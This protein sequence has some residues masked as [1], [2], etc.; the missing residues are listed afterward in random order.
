MTCHCL[1]ARILAAAALSTVLATPA[2]AQ[3]SS[4]FNQPRAGYTSQMNSGGRLPFT[5]NGRQGFGGMQGGGMNSAFGTS[6]FGQGNGS[7]MNSAFGNQM[8]MGGNN[9]FGLGGAN[10]QNSPFN[11]SS[12]D[13]FRPD[14]F[15]G[16]DAADVRATLDSMQGRES[17][18][19]MFDMMIENL[20]EMRDARRRWREQRNAPPRVR[21]RLEPAFD[22]PRPPVG[23]T[24]L[25]IQA[26]LNDT[27]AK[28]AMTGA[29]AQVSGRTA[30]LQGAVNN[31]HERALA[32]QLASLEPGVSQVQ[33]LLTVASIPPPQTLPPPLES[34]AP[35]STLPPPQ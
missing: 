35:A 23:E 4:S 28:R 30:I 20:N 21:V 8:G 16:R 13:M 29:T 33:N 14:G 31:Q 6:A 9:Q 2:M 25:G 32:E 34:T 19:G 11:Q 7:G 5:N 24:A 18:G 26:R 12:N 1:T 3:R 15:V 22:A 27:F 10:Q 17:R